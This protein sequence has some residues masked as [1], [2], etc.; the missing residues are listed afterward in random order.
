MLDGHHSS[1]PTIAS[2][3]ASVP[4]IFHEINPIA[5]SRWGEFLHRHPRASIFHTPE[6][7]EA[8]QRTYGYDP[9]VFTTSLPGEQLQ[10]GVVFCRVKSWLVRPRLVAL[11]FSDHSE[12][13]VS[14][15]ENL[16]KLLTFLAEG[17][18]QG[19]WTSVELRPSYALNTFAN[20]SNF[21]DGQRFVLHSLDLQPSLA[22]LFRGLNKDSTQRKIRKAIRE[23][24]ASILSIV[25]NDAASQI[26]PTASICLVPECSSLFRGACENPNRDDQKWGT[27]RRSLLAPLQGHHAVQIRCER[28]EVP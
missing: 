20:W 24:A 25:G 19:K 11:P 21:Q 14:N 23:T 7:L 3:S 18:A 2:W 17:K 5:D 1:G 13:L 4:P 27:C 9:V 10:D 12:P 16:L 28:R 6:W 15:Q 8:L 22:S 26:A